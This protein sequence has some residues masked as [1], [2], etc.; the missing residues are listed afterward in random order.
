MAYLRSYQK[1]DKVVNIHQATVHRIRMAD[2]EDPDLMVADPIY[3][4]QQTENGKYIM[5]H[6]EDVKWERRLDSDHFGYVYYIV[7]EIEEKK[8]AEYYLKFGKE[9]RG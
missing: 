1:G 4:W 9:H 3:R 2:V 5:E 8:L 6:S 7:A